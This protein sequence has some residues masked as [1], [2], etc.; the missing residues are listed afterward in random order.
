MKQILLWAGLFTLAACTSSTEPESKTAP[1]SVA[2]S[3]SEKIT[4]PM[5][6]EYSDT[7][8]MGDPKNAVTILNL[9]KGWGN[10]NFDSFKNTLADSVELHWATGDV[11]IGPKDSILPIIMAYRNNFSEVKNI[12]HGFLSMRHKDSK[13]DFVLV[14][15]KEI[16]TAKDG[17]KD[18]VELQENWRINSVGKTDWVYQYDAALKPPK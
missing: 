4:Y 6:S 8:E 18:S 7:W 1:S 17:K 15:I 14:W 3:E 10:G 9:Y 5:P 11:N 16:T 12:I 2:S 13:Q